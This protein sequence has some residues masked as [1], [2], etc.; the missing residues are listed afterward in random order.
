[1]CFDISGFGCSVVPGRCA[2]AMLMHAQKKQ[3][4]GV[5]TN[6]Q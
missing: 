5:Q 1:M 6:K 4:R 3:E 2:R